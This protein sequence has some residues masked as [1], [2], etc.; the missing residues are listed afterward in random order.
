MNDVL[1]KYSEL[2][3]LVT[4]LGDIITEFEN[5]GDRSDL[6]RDAVGRPFYRSELTDKASEAESRWDYKRGQLLES[7]GTI[8]QAADGLYKAYEEFDDE[9]AKNFEEGV[10]PTEGATAV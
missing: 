2:E 8:H 6:I 5:A 1:I 7:L 3:T 9:A 10:Q 4:R